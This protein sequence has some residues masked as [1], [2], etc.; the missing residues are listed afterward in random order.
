MR[1]PVIPFITLCLLFHYP[2]PQ[3]AGAQQYYRVQIA[4][5]SAQNHSLSL[6]NSTDIE[7]GLI[8]EDT[9]KLIPDTASNNK[10]LQFTL[11]S[12][13]CNELF[14]GLQDAS[15]D[16]SYAFKMIN[17]QVFIVVGHLLV[18][19]PYTGITDQGLT[20][21][22]PDD[23]SSI[24]HYKLELLEQEISYYLN[25]ALVYRACT[26]DISKDFTHILLPGLI[27]S[28]ELD[29]LLDAW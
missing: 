29:I 9:L 27:S 7:H 24:S 14:I 25:D 13:F 4:G 6:L 1:I 20:I 15:N 11:N 19:G 22:I 16:V 12:P 26:N 21:H 8:D 23:R 10:S 3:E 5:D 28:A 2:W 17:D 18:Q